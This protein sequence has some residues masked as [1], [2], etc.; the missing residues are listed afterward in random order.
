MPAYFQRPENALKRANGEEGIGA[1]RTGAARGLG[2]RGGPGL[3]RGVLPPDYGCTGGPCGLP[4]ANPT[5]VWVWYPF[6]LQQTWEVER[7][8]WEARSRE[9]SLRGWP[10]SRRRLVSLGGQGGASRLRRQADPGPS[11]SLSPPLLGTPSPET[12][13]PCALRPR[14][15]SR[16][17]GVPGRR[18][19]GSLPGTMQARTSAPPPAGPGGLAGPPPGPPADASAP[20]NSAPCFAAQGPLPPPTPLVRFGDSNPFNSFP[21]FFFFLLALIIGSCE[22]YSESQGSWDRVNTIRET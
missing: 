16:H 12:T 17:L 15:P 9:P 10:S 7:R 1:R 6:S 4:A 11:S 20:R 22:A 14:A 3:V 18:K 13:G 5:W 19:H 21:I 8:G 2:G